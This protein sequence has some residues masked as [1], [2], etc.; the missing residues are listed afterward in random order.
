MFSAYGIGG[1]V[2]PIMAG[3]FKDAGA[4]EGLSVWLAPF[5][6]AGALCLVAGILVSTAK[7]PKLEAVAEPVPA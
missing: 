6:I 2:G 1:I 3:M 5:L 4:D 7:E